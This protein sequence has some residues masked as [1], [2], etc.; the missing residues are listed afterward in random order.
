MKH[1]ILGKDHCQFG[2]YT[3]LTINNSFAAISVG[4]DKNSPSKRF[5]GDADCLNEDCLLVYDDG[6]YC[7]HAVA[8]AHFGI[9]SS[10]QL[11]EGL[12]AELEKKRPTSMQ[13]LEDQINAIRPPSPSS[14]SETTLMVCVFNRKQRTG[15]GLSIGDSTLL[16]IGDNTYTI[17]NG[18]K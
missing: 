11:L 14:V 17:C 10:H 16:C 4:S 13:E 15:F 7:L 2:K 1:L 3:S 9:Q 6:E 18:H 5:K 8:D 12:Y